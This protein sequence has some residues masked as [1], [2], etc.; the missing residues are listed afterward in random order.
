MILK[1]ALE[2]KREQDAKAVESFGASGEALDK[3]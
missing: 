1:Q 3:V 2:E